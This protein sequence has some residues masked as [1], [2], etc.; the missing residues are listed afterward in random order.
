[1]SGNVATST[2]LTNNPEV[3]IGL[4]AADLAYERARSRAS[5]LPLAERVVAYRE[6]RERRNA[7]YDA[8]LAMVGGES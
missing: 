3:A 6:A 7:A 5:H 1:M 2:W 4:R 8:V